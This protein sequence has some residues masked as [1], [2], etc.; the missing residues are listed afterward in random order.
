MFVMNNDMSKSRRQ[1][2][3]LLAGAVP[4]PLLAGAARVSSPLPLSFSTL[5]CPGWDWHTILER[6]RNWGYSAIE[7]RGIQDELDLTRRPEFKGSHLAATRSDL[8]AVGLRICCLGASARLHEADGA[9]RIAQIDEAKKYIDLAQNLE[10]PFVRVFGDQLPKEEPEQKV[11]DRVVGALRELGQHAR[12]SGVS[13]LLESHGDFCKSSLLLKVI[14]GVNLANVALLWDVHHTVVSGR[15][16]PA[17]TLASLQRHVRHT[18]LKDSKRDG[19]TVTYVLT[20]K[21]SIPLGETVRLLVRS[22]YNG[23]Y[24]FEWEKRWHP[25]IEEPE[26]AFPQFVAVMKAHL[27]AA[28][29]DESQRRRT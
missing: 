5:G 24:G 14:D 20:G 19:K 27:T 22:G 28:G 17:E 10:A 13:V 18:H 16:K 15:E 2:L 1:F 23:L 6:A 7:L 8:S 25:E 21:G 9:K 11:L 3:R 4:A 26:V 29:R 12:G